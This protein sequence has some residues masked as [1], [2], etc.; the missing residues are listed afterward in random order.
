MRGWG[1]V[2]VALLAAPF[3]AAQA[4]HHMEGEAMVVIAHDSPPDGRAVVGNVAHFA[5][6]LFG[7]DGTP[8]FHHDMLIDVTLN[9]V[10][11]FRTTPDSG[12][13]YDGV[14]GFD[15]IFPVP[16][17]YVVTATTNGQEGETTST[18]KG[19][20]VPLEAPKAATLAIDAPSTAML[21]EPVTLTYG[22]VDADG[23]LLNHT[24]VL[25]E[26]REAG[27]PQSLLF[28]AHTHTHDAQQSLQLALPRPGD[29]D[30][31]FIAYNAFPSKSAAMFPAFLATHK[32]SVQPPP[33]PPAASPQEPVLNF[34]SADPADPVALNLV[35]MGQSDGDYLVYATYDP[36]TLV[37]PFSQVRL[38]TLVVN[39]TTMELV[40]HVNFEATVVD[41]LGNV[42]FASQ[43]L[44]EYDGVLEVLLGE[45]LPGNYHLNVLAERGAWKGGAVLDYTIAPPAAALSAGPQFT[46]VTGLDALVSGQPSPVELFIHDAAG[47]P[48]MHGEVDIQVL[49]AAEGAAPIL[50]TKLH[51]H[52]DGKFPFSVTYPAAGDYI[53]RVAP[54]ALEPRPT[55]LFFGPGP[56]DALDFPI[57]VAAGAPLP[58]LDLPLAPTS[59]P[60]P[61]AP[62]RIPAPGVAL[63]GLAVVGG[64]LLVARRR[65]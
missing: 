44:H 39:K 12:H 57:Q 23:A 35:G 33:A 32:L 17:E 41:S 3:V 1:V 28:R 46:D 65:A 26:A 61:D 34:L 45:Q 64:A 10:S 40:Q 21:G 30:L 14:N 53:L 51:T 18:F 25:V 9:G 16:G 29:F 11:L 42:V 59:A 31:T 36:Y 6:V 37:G 22:I 8:Q 52:D 50:A 38:S 7:K 56:G 19:Y 2:L 13:D 48:F 63:L 54:F 58:A 49:P 47:M 62:Q 55:P 24:D 27:Y 15:V 60:S 43:S 5:A 4:D 20:V